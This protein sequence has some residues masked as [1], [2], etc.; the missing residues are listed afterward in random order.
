MKTLLDVKNTAQDIIFSE[1]LLLDKGRQREDLYGLFGDI[2]A[3]LAA[4]APGQ[5]GMIYDYSELMSKEQR[6]YI[7]EQAYAAGTA[8]RGTEHDRAFVDYIRSLHQEPE[9]QNLFK[10][11]DTLY[12]KL[13]DLLGEAGGL[14]DEYNELYRACQGIVGRKIDVFFNMGYYE[15]GQQDEMCAVK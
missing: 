9:A 10:E 6:L 2:V 13:H 8:A 1:T 7:P 14:L 3:E 11:R 15:T 5:E 12:Y 4:K